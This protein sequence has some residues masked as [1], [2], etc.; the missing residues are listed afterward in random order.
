[1]F[2]LIDHEKTGALDFENLQDLFGRSKIL[3]RE[4]E[5]ISILRVIDINDDGLIDGVKFQFF[6]SLCQG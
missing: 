5:I 4:T 3:L 6:L 1:M 2:E